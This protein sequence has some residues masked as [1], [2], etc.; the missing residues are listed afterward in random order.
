MKKITIFLASSFELASDRNQLKDELYQKSKAWHHKEVFFHLEIWEDL[1]TRLSSTR[2]QDDCNKKIKD[3]DLFV[4]L[5]YSKVGMYTEEEFEI[6]F[7][8]FNQNKK[9]FIFTY[10]KD[11]ASKPEI[12]LDHFKNKLKDLG[13]FHASYRNSD[14]LWNQINKELDRLLLDD[15]EFNNQTK[16]T[17]TIIVNSQFNNA[18]GNQ[19]T[20]GD[21][22]PI[23]N[24]NAESSGKI[25]Q[26]YNNFPN[27]NNKIHNV[28]N[29][30]NTND[31]ATVLNKLLVMAQKGKHI[32]LSSGKDE[33]KKEDYN[34]ALYDFEIYNDTFKLNGN[35]LLIKSFGDISHDLDTHISSYCLNS[36]NQLYDPLGVGYERK[37]KIKAD[38]LRTSED[39]ICKKS[40]DIFDQ[41]RC[42][43]I[44]YENEISEQARVIISQILSSGGVK[45]WVRESTNSFSFSVIDVEP[46]I[47]IKYSDKKTVNQDLKELCRFGYLEYIIENKTY[48]FTTK[49][50]RLA[51]NIN[52]IHEMKL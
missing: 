25:D 18:T 47:D 28:Y 33:Q 49:G 9:P 19:E 44:I 27:Q 23:N 51:E 30:S 35:K 26:T 29:S 39:F 48:D 2:S 41:L 10:F 50:R 1:S 21:N 38:K 40:R 5:A 16:I 37:M 11:I 12:S 7:G 13:H 45:Q 31:A 3:S 32:V 14:H 15:F 42:E 52:L 8:A 34:K 4:L 36:Y 46:N 43:I 6:A 20:R 24:M 17:E 22:S